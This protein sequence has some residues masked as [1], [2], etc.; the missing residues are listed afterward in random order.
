MANEL[1][2]VELYGANNDG[3]PIR[4]TIA[5]GISVSK[6]ELLALVDPRTASKALIATCQ[7]AGVALE[8]HGAGQG[9]TSISCWTD[10]I[11]EAV[12]SGAIGLGAPVTGHPLNYVRVASGNASGATI[13]GY[14]LET[15]SADETIN[16]RIRL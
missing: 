14:A 12:A 1:T 16:V 13:I 9:I 3:N 6:G 8:D 4:F 11:F 15:A 10:G 5:D 7:F 2:K